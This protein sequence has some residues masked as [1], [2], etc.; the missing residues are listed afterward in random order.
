MESQLSILKGIHPGFYLE[1]ELKKRNIRKSRFAI[2]L[3]EF[4]QTLVAI[5]KGKRK[6]NTS[7]AL[8]IEQALDLEE[9]FL[10]VLQI[11][12]DIAEQKKKNVL[13]PDIS[14]IRPVLF[15]DTEIGKID[16]DKQKSSI[17]KRVYSRGN[18]MEKNVI[19][20]FYGKV[21]IEQVLLNQ[22][23]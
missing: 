1:R 10:M 13:K 8:K 17:I 5:T 16:W 20:D 6:M 12:Y 9:G 4:P 23:E 11:Y 3:Q 22:T 14:K 2:S 21:L 18:E 7:L 19:S 15:W